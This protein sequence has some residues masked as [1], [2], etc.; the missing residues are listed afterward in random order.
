[1]SKTDVNEVLK[2]GGRCG[3]AGVRARR[4]TGA[5]IVAELALTLVL[6]AGAGFMMRNFLTLYRLDL[7][8][9]TS[10]L[11]TMA[12]ALPERKYPALEQ[13]LAFYE[14][15]EERLRRN[16]PDSRPSRSPATRRCRAAS[17]RQLTIDGQPLDRRA[18]SAPNVTM[19]T[20]DPRYFET[21]GL[22]L[23][24]RPRLRPTTTARPGRESAIV[25]QRFVAM[26]FPNEDP[27]GRRITLSIDL[28]GGAPPPGGIPTSLDGDHR[29]HRRRT[30]ASATSSAGS[31]SGRLPAVPRRPARLHEPAGAQRGRSRPR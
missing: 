30:C 2:E 26:H 8:I 22:A 13:R 11:L 6:L 24:A 31:R 15:L 12:L 16:R 7:G 23:H 14:R 28:Q 20:I 10:Q 21:V 19:L 17:L 9:D 18:S 5:L 29:R 27:I 3:A 25:N 1:M 4:W